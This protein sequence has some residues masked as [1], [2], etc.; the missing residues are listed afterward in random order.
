MYTSIYK[1]K[2]VADFVGNKQLQQPFI[3]WLLEWN[4]DDTKKKCALISSAGLY[5]IGK[6][7][8]VELMLKKHDCNMIHLALDDE[9]DKDTIIPLLSTKKTFD[10]Q[11]NVLVV[12]DIDCG[13]DY[14]FIIECIK[15]TK[16]PIVCIC[17]NR[18]EQSIKGILP[19]CVDFKMKKPTYQEVYALIYNVVTKEKIRIKEQE[20]RN[21]YE[22]S[23]GDI[24]FILN[25]LQFGMRTG[26]KN[27]QNTNIFDST[28]KLLSMD[29]PL[30]S[31]YATYWLSNDLHTLMIQENY[32]NNTLNCRDAVQKMEN[33][34]YSADALSAADIIESNM[35]MTNW[36]LAPYVALNTIQ[37][38]S[39]C[40]KKGLVKFPQFLG[41]T[42]TINKNRREKR[43]A[44]TA[45]PE[46]K[47]PKASKASKK[48]RA[49]K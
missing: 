35:A 10:G 44:I 39:K 26:S 46:P 20:I 48:P 24:R 9:R 1:P 5:G 27:I 17:T 7:L 4:A 32:I 2:K 37:A 40:N 31:K 34:C 47:A 12:S 18:Y 23:N 11:E 43:A 22:Q 33:L 36:E 41:K 16:I 38:A 15:N 3:E 6:S 45:R 8:F 21:L 29:E 19:Y 28:A 25:T 30:E 49:K 14:G 13:H 42:A